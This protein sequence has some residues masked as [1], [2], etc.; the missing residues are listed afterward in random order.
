M[1]K[2]QKIVC[3]DL[4]PGRKLSWKLGNY[5]MQV[6]PRLMNYCGKQQQKPIK[7]PVVH[8]KQ[9]VSP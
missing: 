9:S 8:G 7:S 6:V 2:R 5:W 3:W 1:N 4:L